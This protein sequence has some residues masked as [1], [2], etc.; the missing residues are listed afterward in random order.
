MV[1]ITI[2]RAMEIQQEITQAMVII[3]EKIIPI[4]TIRIM[5]TKRK[6]NPQMHHLVHLLSRPEHFHRNFRLIQRTIQL[7]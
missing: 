2:I 5:K 3:P 4:R 1:A 7:Q 6:R